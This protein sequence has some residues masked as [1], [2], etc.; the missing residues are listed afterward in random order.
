MFLQFILNKANLLL[1]FFGYEMVK[2]DKKT[3]KPPTSDL[4]KLDLVNEIK[5]QGLR[6]D[7]IAEKL[8]I[9]TSYLSRLLSGERKNA[10]K[11]NAIHSLLKETG[12]NLNSIQ[13]NQAV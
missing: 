1:S 3:L 13:N 11:I 12:M 9:S 2:I 10:Q 4:S 5:R 7:W 6:Q 8:N